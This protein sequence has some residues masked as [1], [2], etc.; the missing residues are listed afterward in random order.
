VE[1]PN[2]FDV[3]NGALSLQMVSLRLLGPEAL[4]RA[5]EDNLLNPLEAGY[6]IAEFRFLSI[7]RRIGRFL[8]Q[9]KQ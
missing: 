7:A 3:L 5:E 2:W 4:A 6:N 1:E 9:F 8:L